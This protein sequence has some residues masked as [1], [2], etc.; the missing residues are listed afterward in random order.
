M[1]PSQWY[2]SAAIEELERTAVWPRCWQPVVRRSQVAEPGTHASGCFAGELWVVTRDAEGA[3]R[4]FHNTCRH[5]GREVVTGH[6]KAEALVCGYHGWRYGLDGRLQHAP[7]MTGVRGFDRA[8]TRLP[9]MACAEWGAWV[10]VCADPDAPPP[11]EALGPAGEALEQR[12]FEALRYV[13]TVEWEIGCNWKVYVDNYLDGGYHIPHMHPSLA[14]Q[15]EMAAYAT[16]VFDRSSLQT[17]P[18]TADR[19][20]GELAYDPAARIGAGA[21]YAWLYPNFMLNRYGPCLD[22]NLVVPLGPDRCRVVYEFYFEGEPSP[23]FVAQSLEQ[24][25]VTQRED[26]EI[27][28]SVQRGLR[29]RGYDRGRYAP[30]VEV[31]EHHFHLLLAADLRA[32]LGL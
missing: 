21:L 15:I 6:G 13:D 16:Q 22:T 28:E 26:I 14:A 11:H 12:G 18:A 2:T 27:C 17:A 5:K 10:W 23:E 7:R 1:P 25:A 30:A 20:G 24:A 31:G 8:A 29:S 19:A 32:E 4:A 9:A 3:L